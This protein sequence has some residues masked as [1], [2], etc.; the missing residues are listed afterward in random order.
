MAEQKKHYI[1]ELRKQA[2]FNIV[3][4][5]IFPAAVTLI[6]FALTIFFFTIPQYKSTIYQEKCQFIKDMT[7]MG[8]SLLEHYY[9]R[10][11]RG[12]LTIQESQQR[13]IERLR[14]LRYGAEQ[15]DYFWINDLQPKVI[16]HPYR[17]DLEGKDLAGDANSNEKLVFDK[18]VDIV[19]KNGAGYAE[20]MWQ[21]KDDPS[22]VVPKLSYVRLFKPWGWIIGT[23]IYTED[24][25]NEV[26]AMTRDLQFI[27]LTIFFIVLM[28]SLYLIGRGTHVEMLRQKA[29]QARGELL[30]KLEEKNREIQ[31]FVY[32]VSHD[33]RAPLIN[34]R[35]F[36]EELN[37]SCGPLLRTGQES[38]EESPP[39]IRLSLAE[40]E[41]IKESVGFIRSNVEKME[42]LINGL[43]ELSRVG[44][45]PVTIQPVDVNEVIHQVIQVF[46]YQIKSLQARVQAGP[47]PPCRADRDQMNQVFSNLIDNALKYRHPDRIPEI[48]ISGVKKNDK[49]EYRI[50]DNGIG[51]EPNQQNHIFD[52]FARIN[53]DPE[54][55]GVGLGLTIVKRILELSGGQIRVES[56]FGHGSVFYLLLPGV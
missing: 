50:S 35:G 15:Q 9:Q 14:S 45:K 53:P 19:E 41:E 39:A 26:S 6:L 20:Y 24:I 5:T 36:S 7:D 54:T 51:I 28:T 46:Q 25:E 1:E 29:E 31:D 42:C 47:L 10:T 44:S 3:L 18:F 32:T 12:E 21:R 34:I 16:M 27:F 43:L 49:T 8:Y 40:R 4:H 13:V 56:Q 37:M 23:G 22:H 30:E 52:I 11:L 2:W 33:L 38:G 55:K 17:P 48:Q